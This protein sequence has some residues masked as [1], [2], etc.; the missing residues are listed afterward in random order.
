[1]PGPHKR[2][3]LSVRVQEKSKDTDLFLKDEPLEMFTMRLSKRDREL[4]KA[5]F[6][7]K[8]LRLSQGVRM[9]LREYLN[10]E[11]IQ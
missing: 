1:M 6:R 10:K 5:H 9:I 2:E 7:S 8:G 4:L 3:D 11:G